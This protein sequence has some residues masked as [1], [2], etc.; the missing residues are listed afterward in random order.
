MPWLKPLFKSVFFRA[1]LY[2]LYQII[3]YNRRI[4]AAGQSPKTGF[5]CAPDVNV[6][7]RWVYIGIALLISALVLF[8]LSN[9]NFSMAWVL[10]AFHGLA[11]L[12]GLFAAH[13]LDFIGHWATVLL[14]NALLFTFLPA[15]TLVVFALVFL[16]LWMWY[17]RWP[18]VNE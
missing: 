12:A 14:V 11:L 10:P 7:Y 5:D 15:N 1:P 13:K 16:S 9:V 2:Q 8:P 3:T 18:Q 6:F 17:R 4:I